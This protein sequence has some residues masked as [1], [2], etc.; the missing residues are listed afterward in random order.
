MYSLKMLAISLGLFGSYGNINWTIYGIE[1]K[2]STQKGAAIA[3]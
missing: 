3:T 2:E 1:P